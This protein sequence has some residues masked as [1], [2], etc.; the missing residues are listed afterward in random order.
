MT[1]RPIR[2]VIVGLGER[3]VGTWAPLL[4][5]MPEF[6]IV[7]VCDAR[8]ERVSAAVVR[9]PELHDV[10]V[11]PSYAEVLA[12]PSV[13]AV[14]LTVRSENQ[15][16]L[17][18]EGLEAGKHVHAEVPAA[19]S[20]EDCWRLVL[21]AERSGSVYMLAE[22]T[23]YW[24]FIQEWRS[25]RESGRLGEITY[26][27]GQYFHYLPDDKYID[28]ETREYVALR[29][30]GETHVE[31]TWQHLMPPIHYLPH[32]LSPILSVLDDRVDTVVAMSTGP[33]SRANDLLKQSDLQVALMRTSRG[34]VLRMAVSFA[35]PHP[36]DNWHWYQ[37]IGTGGRVEFS[38]TSRDKPKAWFADENMHEAVDVDWRFERSD[39]PP[40]AQGSGHGDAD[41]Y[42]HRAFVDAVRGRPAMDVYTAVETAAPA[43]VAAE[44]IARGSVPLRVPDFRPGAHRN[45]GCAPTPELAQAIFAGSLSPEQPKEHSPFHP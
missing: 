43:I 15:G 16:A 35:Q 24:G 23:R 20:L 32:E 34:A 13:D 19:H 41:Y 26:A 28:R 7:G 29:D 17:A 8:S 9:V 25:L 14:A 12:D 21:A 10:H 31:P 44:S 3:A 37:V 39:A 38:R 42:A 5:L 1:E 11:Y 2:I 18:A 30:V 6:E 36:E 22:Q 40:E 27:E 4:L 45:E 33:V